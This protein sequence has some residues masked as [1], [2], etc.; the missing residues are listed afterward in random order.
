ME[1][2]NIYDE[3]RSDWAQ[4]GLLWL[5]EIGEKSTDINHYIQ[6]IFNRY[7][8]EG[9]SIDTSDSISEVLESMGF[10][11][12]GFMSYLEKD[13]ELTL[14]SRQELDT[15]LSVMATPTYYLGGEP[16]QGRQHLPLIMNRLG[17]TL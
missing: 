3:E 17:H 12:R 5:Q 4:L 7:W 6:H 13:S 10:N 16:Y 15:E 2:S 9:R 11:A 14:L 8:V 1:L